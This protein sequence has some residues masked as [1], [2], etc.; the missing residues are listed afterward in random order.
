MAAVVTRWLC[1]TV[2]TSFQEALNTNCYPAE[3]SWPP[4][5]L[6]ETAWPLMVPTCMP[7]QATG[8]KVR[9]TTLSPAPRHL[10]PA[11]VSPTPTPSMPLALNVVDPRVDA[12]SR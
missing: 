4:S 11:V 8:S 5:G 12:Q 2:H 10:H 1:C 7:P 3:H 9:A 6:P